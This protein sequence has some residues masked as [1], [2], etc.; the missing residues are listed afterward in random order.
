MAGIALGDRVRIG[1]ILAGHQLRSM[2]TGAYAGPFSRWRLSGGAPDRL[3]VA[4]HDLRTADP[5]IAEDFYSGR[6]AL[7]GSVVDIG[8]N[9]PFTIDPPSAEWQRALHGFGWLRHMRAA[10]TELTRLHTRALIADWINEYGSYDHAVWAPEIIA[11]RLVSWL[12]HSPLILRGADQAFY[13]RFMRSLARQVRYLARAADDAPDGTPRLI[14]VIALCYAGLC[15]TGRQRLLRQSARWLDS[16]LVRQVLPDGGHVS[17]NPD[18]I[19]RIL[20]DLLPLRQTFAARDLP[21]SA[22]LISAIDRMMP[23]LRFFR[24]GDGALA[25]FNGMGPTYPDVMATLLA[26]DES[27][28]APVLNASY[29]GYQRLQAADT[30][31][32][33]DTGAPPPPLLSREAHAGCLSFEFSSGPDRII[34]NCGVPAFGNAQWRVVSRSTA[35]HSTA[36]LEDTSSCRFATSP[37]VLK[38]L[39]PIMLS[40]P[41]NVTVERHDAEVMALSAGHDGYRSD[42][43]ILHERRIALSPDG[44]RID[45]EDVFSTA[46]GAGSRANP[47]YAVRFHLHPGVRATL[48]RDHSRAILAPARG[49]PW[50]LY[51][52]GADIS[53][54][55]SV[56]LGG[57]DGARRTDQIVVHGRARHSPRVT[58]RLQRLDRRERVAES[59]GEPGE[60]PLV[61]EVEEAVVAA[62]S[63]AEA[64]A[65][66][67]SEDADPEE[68]S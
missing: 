4:P 8:G 55:E 32:I 49:E 7:A 36:A 52:G 63:D 22:A 42:F 21:P 58:W 20:L 9:S 14:C 64:E 56:Y 67:V 15:M 19:V 65:P 53:I 16:E 66:E 5:T 37:M 38:K 26:Y 6:Y 27:R 2:L 41:R 62:P 17:R 60:L 24:H 35:A 61:S 51:A 68:R 29:S 33:V 59:P 23:M 43:G 46:A 48:T 3:T 54:E 25:H 47:S 12:S 11:R 10:D 44:G 50:E 39:G 40:G 34:V 45:G 30:V 1:T 13:R 28:G 57:L 18:A 31:I